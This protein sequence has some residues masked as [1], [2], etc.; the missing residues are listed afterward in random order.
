MSAG[1]P[2]GS[3]LG[4]ILWNIGYDWVL[5]GGTMAGIKVLCYADDTLVLAQQRTYR[6]AAVLA[7]AGVAEVVGRIRRLGLEV[8]LNKSEALYFHAPRKG[9]PPDAHIIV[10]GVNIDVSRSMKYLGLVLDGRWS[11]RGH[12]TS[13]APK[14]LK[15]AGALARLLPNVAGPSASSRRL[16]T[17]VVRSMALYGAPVW[18]DALDRH[19][20][21]LL[22]RA[23]RVMAIRAIRG[24]RTISGEVA[25]VL[26]GVMP[27]DLDALSLAS[28][29]CRRRGLASRDPASQARV[30]EERE[31][32][33]EVWESRL[34]TPS[35]GR[36]T[37][38]AVRPVFRQWLARR[39]NLSHDTGAHGAWLL[40]GLP[41][42][43]RREGARRSLPPL[44]RLPR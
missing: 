2:Q 30:E 14:L 36:L 20:V 27:W 40:R 41:V 6:E 4:P 22:R 28:V 12:F 23:Q 44:R 10:G 33:M 29:Y 9:P 7:T 37:I 8:A 31:A 34:A 13:L 15:T 39:P 19:N 35:A 21:T 43:D 38:E 24:Y 18:A 16:Y 17:G 1:V 11:F 3:V 25:C 26:A 5:R 32:A 42:S